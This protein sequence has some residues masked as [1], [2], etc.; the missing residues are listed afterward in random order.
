MLDLT[1]GRSRN[2]KN[3]TRSGSWA[4]RVGSTNTEAGG[5]PLC[6]VPTPGQRGA[7]AETPL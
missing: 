6:I 4:S 5:R 1:L 3:G 7:Q 2:P